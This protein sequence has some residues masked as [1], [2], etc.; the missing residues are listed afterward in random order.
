MGVCR[1]HRRKLPRPTHYIDEKVESVEM[2]IGKDTSPIFYGDPHE[3]TRKKKGG[4]VEFG[5]PNKQ[6]VVR[7]LLPFRGNP[8]LARQEWLVR[9]EALTTD[10]V[11]PFDVHRVINAWN[12]GSDPKLTVDVNGGVQLAGQRGV[13]WKHMAD[14]IEIWSS[15]GQRGI[16]PP[17]LAAVLDP[18][19]RVPVLTP[20][21][22]D[23]APPENRWISISLD[24]MGP[25]D[26]QLKQI[27]ERVKR[28]R[29]YAFMVAG[30]PPARPGAKEV[31]R[32][33]LIYTLHYS[34]G[35]TVPE[36]AKA[37]FPKER[38]DPAKSK[39]KK[40]IT[41]IRA[42]LDGVEPKSQS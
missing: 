32:D 41:A 23:H 33:V 37:V 14:A 42:A 20:P 26:E 19:H 3:C 38:Q 39:I 35:L 40:R 28:L 2:S 18:D 12:A 5:L 31:G 17:D 1:T 36:I 11:R 9:D 24:L 16:Y 27:R 22:A 13:I 8:Y 30:R 6:L 15:S 25:L 34:A 7:L 10:D 21:L 4:W 29:S